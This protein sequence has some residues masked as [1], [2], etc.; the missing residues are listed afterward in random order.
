MDTD[1]D[2]SVKGIRTSHDIDVVVTSKH[3]GFQVKWIVECKCWRTAIS[4]LHVFA[5]REIVIDIGAD[6]GILLSEA[7]FQ[8]G[9]REAAHL[10]NV[11]LTSLAAL[12]SSTVSEVFA[13]RFLDL[14]DSIQASRKRY[15][16]IGKYDRIKHGLRPDVGAFGY[17][18][19]HVISASDDLVK[20]RCVACTLSSR[21]NYHA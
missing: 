4:K 18:G 8:S 5:L 3:A 9:A 19:D 12:R 11:Q 1:T 7:G 10:T 16:A 20:K 13:V 17:M 2:K 15:W 21:R 6:R 14:Y